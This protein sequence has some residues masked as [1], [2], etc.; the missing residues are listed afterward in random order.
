MPTTLPKTQTAIAI[1]GKRLPLIQLPSP[2]H[3]PAAGEVV[4]RVH[5]TAS[6]PL[7]LHIADGNLL[8]KPYP[9]L[10]GSGG[11]AGEVVAV[12]SQGQQQDGVE[13]DL[14]GLR[15][16]DKV[17][18]FAF[19]GEKEANHQEYITVPAFLVSKI[20]QGLSPAAAVTIPVNL[21]TVFHTVTHDLGLELPWPVPTTPEWKDSTA[22]RQPILIW[23]AGSSVGIFAVQVLRHWGYTS[24]LAVASGKH[25]QYL[26]SLGASAVFDYTKPNVTSEI[27]DHA[28]TITSTGSSSAKIPYIIDCIGS[29]D[30]T[31]KPLTQIAEPGSRVAVMLPVILKDATVEDEPEYEMD[32]AKVLPGQWADGVELRGVRTHFY[33][34][35]LSPVF[36]SLLYFP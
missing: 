30:G 9:S 14:K 12:G 15:V 24:I 25:H 3:P 20:P 6:T 28:A 10:S 18:S 31:L 21:V 8:G 27:R 4:I 33:L 7:D 5:W 34:E 36:L 22:L 17:T 16:G 1:P 29:I 19:R 32:V 2:V 26:T 13:A 23:G 11:V 35:V